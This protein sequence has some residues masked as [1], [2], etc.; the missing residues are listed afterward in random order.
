MANFT[1]ETG[2][3]ALE[4]SRGMTLK[5]LE[6]IPADKRCHQPTP[7]ANH[8]LWV[9]GH[10]AN[11]DDFFLSTL[12]NSEPKLCEKHRTLFG[13]G[14]KPTANAADYPAYED[15]LESL[16][17]R[18]AALLGWY[19]TLT[20]ETMKQP[21]PGDLAQFAPSLAAFAS[22]LA[23]HEGLHA[24]QISVVRKSLGLAPAIG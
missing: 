11:T 20:D 2:K 1:I 3:A 22:T 13:M 5:L 14:S 16:N 6:G 10:L 17:T 15:I 9:L 23:W 19:S 8:V 24:G 12:T 21:L 18:R 7:A 4:F